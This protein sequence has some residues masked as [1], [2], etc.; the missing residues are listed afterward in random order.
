MSSLTTF[1]AKLIGLYC[2]LIALTMFVNKDLMIAAAGTLPQNAAVLVLSGVFALFF[3]LA[4]VLAHNVWSGGVLPVVVTV[5]G[6]ASLLKGVTLLALP[7]DRQQAYVAALHYA[8]YA[9]PYAV[10]TLLV[11]VYLTYA[12]FT[13]TTRRE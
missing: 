10:V 7:A 3:G 2:V 1:L 6:W 9:Y 13:A 5:I 12:G 4:I 8:D 11:G